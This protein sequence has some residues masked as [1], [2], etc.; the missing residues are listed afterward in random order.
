MI[1]LIIHGCNGKMGKVV[2][3]LAK[4]NPEF[5]V[6]A[7]VDKNTFPLDFPV[8]SDLKEVKEEADVVI[9]FSYHEA[10]PNLVKE[11]AKRKIPVVIATT[12]LSEE[13]LKTVEEASKEIPIFRSANM[14]LGIN[15]LISLVKEAAKV[16]EGFDIEIVEKHHNMKKDAPSGTALMIA[17]A[18]NQ[19]LPEKREYVYGRYTKTEQ[20][21][22]NEI[23]IHAVRGGTIV[24]EHDVIFAGPN[25]VITISH[26]AQSR[27]VFGY[28][29]LKAAKFL[30]GQKPGLYTMEDLVKKG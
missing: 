1:R 17:D 26:S 19:V 24:G 30:I 10:I 22:P 9:D 23:G 3:K 29:A 27:E 18:I 25:E 21:K 28:G 11:A 5:E 8:Y 2:A 7:G 15:V 12:G 13:E 20:R 6:V 14:S 4:E 16:L